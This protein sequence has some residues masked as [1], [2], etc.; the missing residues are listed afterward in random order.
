MAYA[1][2]LLVLLSHGDEVLGDSLASA[3]R[4]A[5]RDPQAVELRLVDEPLEDERARE[6]ATTAQASAVGTVRFLDDAHL[7]ARVRVYDRARG[8]WVER[9]LQF[10]PVDAVTEKGRALGFTL[11][12]MV[13]EAAARSAPDEAPAPA[14]VSGSPTPEPTP[15]T[16]VETP[17]PTPS[18]PP[19]RAAA[20]SAP[21]SFGID[22]LLQAAL[23]VGGEGSALGGRLG[24]QYHLGEH[25]ALRAGA[26]LR[27]GQLEA[28][29]ANLTLVDLGAGVAWRTVDAGPGQR[30]ALAVHLDA[31][32]RLH[33]V[34]RAQSAMHPAESHGR[35]LPAVGVGAELAYGITRE[36][37]LLVDAAAHA[38][39]GETELVLRGQQIAAIAPVDLVLGLGARASF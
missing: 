27:V 14:V 15:A 4:A 1:I 18:S 35:F 11:G 26:A 28:L 39:L 12:S 6:L 3:A 9:T 33:H 7:Q 31:L 19:P 25:V 21:T 32:A 8:R 22:A 38:L 36:F 24:G 2:T 30:L 20:A 5:V 16:P 29:E 23:A 13:S 17:S 37:A 10:A 34:A